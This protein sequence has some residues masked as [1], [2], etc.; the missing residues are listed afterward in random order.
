MKSIIVRN[1]RAE[2]FDGI[3]D[4]C[5]RVYPNMAPWK[6]EQL[7]AHRGMFP[8]GQFVAVDEAAGGRIVGMAASLVV[9]WA[10]YAMGDD[11]RDFTERG[12]FTNHDPK[13]GRTLYGA[14]VMVDPERQG[15]GIGS[16]IYRARRD[17]VR[18]LRLV[19][20]LA[21][22]RLAGYHRYAERLSPVEYVIRVVRG[23]I[24]D[25][26]LSFQLGR[27]FR[28]IGVVRNYLGTPETDPET[29]GHA[30]VIEW[31]NREVA[32]P[33]DRDGQDPRFRAP[34]EPEPLAAAPP[35][36]TPDVA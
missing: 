30:A 28:V 3:V 25:P 24:G 9:R 20:I 8:D 1:T 2:D 18:R 7:A 15:A 22:A 17:L 31:L 11:F 29:L 34:A 10:D 23:E 4:L 32:T 26:T 33:A 5:R 35:R 6:H 19:R 27:G 14:E 13:E 21:G 36:S 16:R 12:Y